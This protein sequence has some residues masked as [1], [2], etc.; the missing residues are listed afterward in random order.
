M[1]ARHRHN[2]WDSAVLSE[3][4]G[5]WS[6]AS[7]RRSGCGIGDRVRCSL[8]GSCSVDDGVTYYSIK[9]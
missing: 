3:H 9:V 1:A 2:T 8:S 4:S 6:V 7:S 5:T